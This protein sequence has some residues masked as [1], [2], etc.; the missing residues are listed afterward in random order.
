MNAKHTPGPWALGSISRT[1]MQSIDGRSNEGIYWEAFT[2]VAVR[3]DGIPCSEGMAN[4]RLIAAAPE[5]LDCLIHLT[6][7]DWFKDGDCGHVVCCLDADK[8]RSAITKATGENLQTK[9]Q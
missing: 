6:E 4:A 9:Q 8:V 7:R 2:E 5:L 1:G 3:L